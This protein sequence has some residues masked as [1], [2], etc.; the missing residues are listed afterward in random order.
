MGRVGTVAD[1]PQSVQGGGKEAGS[2]A[3]RTPTGHALPEIQV[4]LPPKPAGRLPE[5]TVARRALHGR[6]AHATFN[7]QRH[8]RRHRLQAMYGLLHAAGV[9]NCRHPHVYRGPALRRDDVRAEASVYGAYVH[10]RPACWIIEGEERLDQ[11]RELQ[12][13]ASS[14]L[15]VQARVSGL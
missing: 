8:A 12:D 15:R 3:V 14:P 11:V 10:R 6:T 1:G 13:G 9:L 2:A 5:S 4:K 7:T